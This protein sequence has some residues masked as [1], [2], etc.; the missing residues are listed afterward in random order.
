MRT[1]DEKADPPNGVPHARFKF[2]GNGGWGRWVPACDPD[3]VPNRVW[4]ARLEVA[5]ANSFGFGGPNASLV[6]QRHPGAATG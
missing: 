5:M 1:Q 2:S 6:L 3:F 4:P